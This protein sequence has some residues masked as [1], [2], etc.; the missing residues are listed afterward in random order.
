MKKLLVILFCFFV[1]LTICSTAIAAGKVLL[2]HSYHSGYAWT[3][4]IT[5][6]VKKGLEN[7]GVQLEIFYIDSKRNT[8]EAWKIKASQMAKKKVASFKPDVVI[9]ADDNTQAYFA[10]DYVGKLKPQ[11][12]FC[13]VNAEAS[14]YGYPSGN[15]TGI[16]E[17]LF[18]VQSLELLKQIKRDVLT[19]AV[20]ADDGPT[21]D[22]ALAY[23]K[24]LKS[25]LK[26]ISFDQPSTFH[27]W[28]ALIK[29]YQ[30]TA[31]AIA[32]LAYQTVKQSRGAES[33][34]P[35]E[36][37]NWTMANNKKPTVGFLEFAMTDGVLCGIAESGEEHGLLS[38]EIARKILKGKK[39]GDF[40]IRTAQKGT[41][42]INVKIARKLGIDIPA[43]IIQSAQRIIE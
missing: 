18:F 6:G 11:L 1:P 30:A 32:I 38:A 33:M 17:R 31:D 36:V 24:T 39:A 29:K 9:A 34:N 26:I 25:P 23:I 14:E 37:M 16:L 20:I 21:S 41:L 28:Q 3:D 27:E 19:I 35:K 22:A 15:V 10:E 8:S 43:H 2:V 40:Q 13:G 7:S 4:A 5:A 12:V 42:I